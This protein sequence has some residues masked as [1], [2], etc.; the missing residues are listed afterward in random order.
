ME[1]DIACK[2]LKK[3]LDSLKELADIT[4]IKNNDYFNTQR[5]KPKDL[6]KFAD[7]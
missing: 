6:E 1:G 3:D 2:L 4:N 7:E 5:F